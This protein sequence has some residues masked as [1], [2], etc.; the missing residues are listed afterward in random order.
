[1]CVKL[2]LRD[3]NPGLY[4]SHPTSTY[5]CR[6]TVALRVCGGLCDLLIATSIVGLIPG[7]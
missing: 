6:M 2:F 5:T 3:L 1:M 4:P 7:F